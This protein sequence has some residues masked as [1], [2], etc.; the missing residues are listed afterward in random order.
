MHS[1]LRRLWKD[2]EYSGGTHLNTLKHIFPLNL[3]IQK[4]PVGSC[5]NDMEQY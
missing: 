1:F 2:S 4:S 5:I 3:V